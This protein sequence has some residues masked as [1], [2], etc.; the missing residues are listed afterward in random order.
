MHLLFD[1]AGR[2]GLGAVMG[3][4]NLKA[5]AIRGHRLP[6]IASAERVKEF[7]EWPISKVIPGFRWWC[8]YGPI[9][10]QRKSVGKKFPSWIIPKRIPPL[11][12]KQ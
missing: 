12:A 1:A 3:S 8:L 10:S 9:G 11:K 7:R 4:K 2:G 6:L 5:I